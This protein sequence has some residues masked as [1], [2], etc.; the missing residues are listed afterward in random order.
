MICKFKNQLS[1][2]ESI[3]K[4]CQLGRVD[5]QKLK[6]TGPRQVESKLNPSQMRWFW[7]IKINLSEW[8][9]VGT[10]SDSAGLILRSEKS[11]RLSRVDFKHPSASDKTI[12][13][14]EIISSEST[15]FGAIFV[16]KIDSPESNQIENQLIRVESLWLIISTELSRFGN[17][18]S[19]LSRFEINII[20][21][22]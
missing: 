14:F 5:L 11:T 1:W 2:A 3:L 18:S 7:K 9:Q 6:S 8:S 13:N 21:S 20:S 15:C 17:N 22:T 10:Q 19:G 4:S 12:W 16:I